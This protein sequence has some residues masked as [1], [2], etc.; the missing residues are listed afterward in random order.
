MFS[1]NLVKENSYLKLF[2]QE[3]CDYL[4]LA[5]KELYYKT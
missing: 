1:I 3:L 5:I 4:S 2:L